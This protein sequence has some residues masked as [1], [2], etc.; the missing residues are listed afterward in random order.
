MSSRPTAIRY[1]VLALLCAAAT[2][3]YLQRNGLG[4][5]VPLITAD[6]AISKRQMGLVLGSF[7]ATYALVQIPAALLASRW[8]PRKALTLYAVL[9]SLATAAIS[10]APNWYFLLAAQLAMGAAQ[11]GLFPAATLCITAWLPAT[12]RG[13]STG[14]LASCMSVGAAVGASLAGLLLVR[15]SWRTMFIFYALPGLAWAACFGLFFRNDP[16]EHPGVNEAELDLIR[17]GRSASPPPKITAPTPWRALLASPALWA[18]CGQHVFRSAGYIFYASWFPTYLREAHQV[19]LEASGVLA[20]LPLAAVVV[21]S[22]LGG[23]ASDF[24]LKLT[25]S[26]LWGRQVFACICMLLCAALILVAWQIN[27]AMLAVGILAAGS[28][29]AAF[30]GPCA[31]AITMDMGGRQV[32]AVFSIMNATGA[33]GALLFPVVIP[34]IV[35]AGGWDA[36]LFTFAGIYVGAGACWLAFNANGTIVPQQ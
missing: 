9:W 30:G 4:V 12:R 15:L 6:L 7:F 33:V 26:R 8:Q 24:V 3:A 36:V 27:S 32:A 18:I 25:G 34:L 22:P 17:R 2:I 31:Y 20:S 10:L 19:S 29:C 11:A 23:Q 28:F 21:G 5:A 1:Y 16:G 13:V 35:E 14:A